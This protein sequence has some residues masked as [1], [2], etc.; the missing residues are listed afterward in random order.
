MKGKKMYEEIIEQLAESFKDD[1]QLVGHDFGAME[2]L[3][4]QKMQLLG[5]GLVQKLV[6]SQR[7][8][9]QGSSL[10]CS[11]GG[12]MKFVQH[13]NRDIH[14]L[15]GWIKIRRAYYY[16]AD[17]GKSLVPYDKSSGLG[18]EQVSP[19]L[20]Q[21]CC[22]LAVDDS[23]EMVSRK[24]EEL[25]GQSVSDD[26]VQKVVHHVGTVAR[27]QQAQEFEEFLTDKQ[28]P[29][30]QFTAQRLYITPD[31]TT[32]CEQ[33]GW[34]EAKV[35]C[36]YWQDDRLGR[37]SRYVGSFE[38]SQRFGWELWLEACR[39]GLRQAKEV[40][41][42]GDGAGWIRTEHA[43]HFSRATF[44][45]DWY[46]ASQHIWDC[47]KALFGESTKVTAKWAN[48]RCDWLWEGRTKR[49]LDDIWLRRKRH[50]GHKR[51]AL[52]DLIKYISTN[53]EQMQ[54]DVFRAKGYDIGSGAVEA[55][56]K[57][58]V[59]KRLKQSGMRWSR[60]G[61]ASTLALRTTWLNED[62]KKLWEQKPLAA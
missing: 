10:Y 38:D 34:H 19:G 35:G 22:L 37:R 24:I 30:A 32:V 60:A 36:I 62:W 11:C 40:V 17:C 6:N 53:E 1:F 58:V 44:I 55:A 18:A 4:Q 29:Q 31:G 7:N 39:C 16:C 12:S 52:D 49:L 23:F 25:F 27:D 51:D 61:S 2:E 5:S 57:N 13:R 3:V 33:D 21:A 42:I 26:T 41:Y 28:I 43:S 47:A 54:Y 56:C 20:A 48:D 14:T 15:F 45:I 50:R 59:G 9:Y 8:G 46:H